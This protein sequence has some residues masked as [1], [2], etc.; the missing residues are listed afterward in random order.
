M[1]LDSLISFFIAFGKFNNVIEENKIVKTKLLTK[2][3]IRLPENLLPLEFN[4]SISLVAKAY[5]IEMYTKGF[6]CHKNPENGEFAGDRLDNAG[7]PYQLIGENLAITPTL[8][9]GH[10][11]LMSSN[12]HRGTILDANYK[13]VG[14]AVVSGPLGLIIVQIFSS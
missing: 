1:R 3:E 12:S 11:S 10:R 4:Q 9:S 6:W 13:R 14:L 5:A 7:I 8:Q 2:R